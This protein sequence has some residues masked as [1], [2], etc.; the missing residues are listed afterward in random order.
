MKITTRVPNYSN[1]THLFFCLRSKDA[2]IRVWEKMKSEAK[3]YN[4]RN[5][6]C[7]I[8][9]G[10]GPST[11]KTDPILEQVCDLM[12][13]GCSGIADVFDSDSVITMSIN[14]SNDLE[15]INE[16]SQT[17]ILDA[18]LITVSTDRYIIY[19]L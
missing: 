12:G 19:R 5:R 6:S 18:E 3:M 13:R 11:L 7:T 16:E 2:L 8:G 17:I 14:N 10:G 1:Y 15:L 4:S 9:T